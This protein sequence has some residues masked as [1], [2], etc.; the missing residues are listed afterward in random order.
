M[1]CITIYLHE[2]Q[3]KI[4]KRGRG[5]DGERFFKST[6]KPVK[7]TLKPPPPKKKITL[8][9]FLD[10][11]GA[12]PPFDPLYILI[13]FWMLYAPQSW[14]KTLFGCFQIFFLLG[15]FFLLMSQKV[16][17][18]AGQTD[19]APTYANIFMASVDIW[20]EKCAN[21]TE[22]QAQISTGL[23]NMTHSNINSDKI[24]YILFLKR[25]IDDYLIFWTGTVEDF[26]KFMIKINSMHPTL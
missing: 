20:L 17:Q 19:A 26:E 25:F 9:G 24:N 7:E 2:R 5:R 13:S 4:I 3:K 11:R 23:N 14:S 1:Q 12:R 10:I 16:G 21:K 18:W 6:K 8:K 22:L 15:S